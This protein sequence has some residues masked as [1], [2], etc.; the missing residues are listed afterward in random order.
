[1]EEEL[2]NKIN[3]LDTILIKNKHHFEFSVY[4]KPTFT[5]LYSNW[6]SLTPMNYKI[7]LVKCLLHRTFFICSNWI[8]IDKQF[9]FIQSNLIKNGFPLDL[10]LNCIKCFVEKNVNSQLSL[11]YDVPKLN[12]F[13]KLIYLERHVPILNCVCS[14]KLD[15]LL[16]TCSVIRTLSL[17]I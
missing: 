16:P 17:R 4:H 5:G 12:I 1:M 3:F 11:N 13:L 6:E 9:K 15:F 2:N 14:L 8:E 7:N 10:I